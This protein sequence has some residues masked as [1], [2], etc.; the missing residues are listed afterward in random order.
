MKAL[1]S[2]AVITIAL[3]SSLYAHVDDSGDIH[4]QV[5]VEGEQFAVYFR[6]TVSRETLRT[7]LG[8]DGKVIKQR[9][10]VLGFPTTPLLLKLPGEGTG[11]NLP[12][13]DA[14]YVMPRISTSSGKRFILV[15]RDGKKTRIEL[16]WS[17][18]ETAWVY[19]AAFTDEHLILAASDRL[20][21]VDD[22]VFFYAFSRESWDA[23]IAKPMGCPIHIYGLPLTSAVLTS[24]GKAYVSWM[25][26]ESDKG[27][28]LNLSQ[29]DPMTGRVRTKRIARGHRNS[30]PSMAVS[31][32]QIAIAFHRTESLKYHGGD[33]KI[34]VEI[35]SLKEVFPSSSA[36][37]DGSGEP[38]TPPQSKPEGKENPNSGA[39]ERPR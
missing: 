22:P 30:S 14:L 28:A 31:D 26:V 5:T 38:A 7:T 27:V 17:S 18:G 20:V 11:F 8:R 2:A 35:L 15:L 12:Q 23:K 6:D 29:F 34:L 19:G 4:P 37:Q 25:A 16:T 39:E 36:E 21:R 3:A 32:G 33:A 9:E 13:P 1:T 10:T 24:R